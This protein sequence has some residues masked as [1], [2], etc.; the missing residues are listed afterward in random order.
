M[1]K[2]KFP[3]LKRGDVVQVDWGDAYSAG[4]WTDGDD[5]ECKPFEVTLIGSVL[6]ANKKGILL[7][8]GF[9]SDGQGAGRFFVPKGMIHEVKIIIPKH[10]ISTWRS[11]QK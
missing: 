9:A 2:K 7:T 8:H 6:R 10:K 11:K 5:Y 4:G 1:A 3:K